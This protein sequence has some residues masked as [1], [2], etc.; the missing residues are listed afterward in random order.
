M[1]TNDSHDF[2][3]F[4]AETAFHN[5]TRRYVMHARDLAR[6][7]QKDVARDWYRFFSNAQAVQV[8]AGFGSVKDS[9]LKELAA[10]IGQL[11]LEC[12][13][14]DV[15]DWKTDIQATRHCLEQILKLLTVRNQAK[16]KKASIT[17]G[18]ATSAL[19]SFQNVSLPK[20]GRK[21]RQIKSCIP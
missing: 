16:K 10:D 20:S 5:F 19:F 6:S 14:L 9:T 12:H 21:T 2:A 4:A 1:N 11:G 3:K 13:P 15:A 17:R 8:L 18:A 7:G